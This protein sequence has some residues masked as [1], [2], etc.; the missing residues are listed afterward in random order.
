MKKI[1]TYLSL[2]MVAVNIGV[3]LMVGHTFRYMAMIYEELYG[4]DE[5]P[6]LTH[7]L[8][9][10]PWWPC[11]FVFA[12]LVV[13]VISV[14]TSVKSST[15][16]HCISGVL[17]IEVICLASTTYVIILPYIFAMKSCVLLKACSCFPGFV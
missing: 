5:I 16:S 1:S 6:I 7:R 3:V 4:W 13:A 10:V 12:G 8:L 9:L 11:I 14:F 17:I 2:L 15:I